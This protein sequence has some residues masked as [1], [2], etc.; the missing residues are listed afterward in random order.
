M[1]WADSGENRLRRLFYLCLTLLTSGPRAFGDLVRREVL[2][3]RSERPLVS[4]WIDQS[5]VTITPKHIRYRHR[6]FRTRSQCGFERLVDIVDIEMNRH[7]A[8]PAQLGSS[9]VHIRK[10]VRNKER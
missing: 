10:L 5:P 7:W 9:A 1:E 8:A 6:F 4:E 3:M 2:D